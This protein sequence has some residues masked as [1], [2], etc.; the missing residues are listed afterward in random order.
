MGMNKTDFDRDA[1]Q[2]RGSVVLGRNELGRS[3]KVLEELL[4]ECP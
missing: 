2:W 1:E 3:C 4:N